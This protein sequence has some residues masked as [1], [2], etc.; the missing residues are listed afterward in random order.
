MSIPDIDVCRGTSTVRHDRDGCGLAPARCASCA[1]TSGIHFHLAHHSALFDPEKYTH[2]A[3]KLP[4]NSAL[5]RRSPWHP[6]LST[7]NPLE[8]GST[9][10]SDVYVLMLDNIHQIAVIRSAAEVITDEFLHCDVFV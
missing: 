3:T 2:S 5:L 7:A 9:N 8:L 10:T 6:C 1:L 4:E